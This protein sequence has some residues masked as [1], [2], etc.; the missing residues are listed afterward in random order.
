MSERRPRV[1]SGKVLNLVFLD[2]GCGTEPDINFPDHDQAPGGNE[3]GVAANADRGADVPAKEM[4]NKK[5]AQ[6]NCYLCIKQF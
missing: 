5:A 1:Q 4:L 2:P 3:A 6:V